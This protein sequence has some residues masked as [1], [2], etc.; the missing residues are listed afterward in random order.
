MAAYR[1]KDGTLSL[2]LSCLDSTVRLKW[3]QLPFQR[4][5]SRHSMS[6]PCRDESEYVC[7]RVCC[8][9][10]RVCYISLLGSCRMGTYCYPVRTNAAING[11]RSDTSCFD[12]LPFDF[13]S[14]ITDQVC[15]VP[16]EVIKKGPF[17]TLALLQGSDQSSSLTFSLPRTS[18]LPIHK[19]LSFN[20]RFLPFRFVLF[21]IVSTPD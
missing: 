16:L 20:E 9:V 7:C 1:C 6:V 4:L 12:A 8:R 5:Y 2:L 11:W 15:S 14:K 21:L 10:C 3:D 19:P 17:V 18:C 13:D